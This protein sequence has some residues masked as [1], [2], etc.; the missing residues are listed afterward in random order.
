MLSRKEDIYFLSLS[1]QQKSRFYP[2]VVHEGYRFGKVALGQ[3]STPKSI[4]F[5]LPVII[6]LMLHSPHYQVLVQNAH[7][8]QHYQETQSDHTPTHF[9]MLRIRGVIQDV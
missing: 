3:V 7:M 4:G 6:P 9:F 5:A 2:S 8:G 1:S